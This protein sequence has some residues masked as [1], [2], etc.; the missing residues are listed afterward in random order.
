MKLSSLESLDTFALLGPGFGGHPFVL[1]TD[2]RVSQSAPQ[3]VYASFEC[4]G[5]QAQGFVGREHAVVI[6]FDVSPRPIPYSL[7]KEHYRED[8]E[9]IRNAIAAGDV[10]QVCHT[11]RADLEVESG[12]E[13]LARMCQRAIPRF[14]A[15]VRLA[16]GE[17]FVSAS[18]ELFFE[19]KGSTIRAE[20]MKGTAPEGSC[21]VLEGSD[22]DRAELAMITDLIRNDLAQVCRPGSVRVACERRVLRLPYALQTVSDVVGEIAP[23]ATPITALQVMHPGGSVTGTPKTAAIAMIRTLEPTARGA[24]CGSLGLCKETEST[25][26]ILIRTAVR[27]AQGWVY[28]VGGGIVFDSDWDKELDEVY[29]KLGALG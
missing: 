25:F 2:L 20:P 14:A 28:G 24:Y 6:D 12:A 18:P 10:Y 19:I 22:K 8:I 5:N 9:A 13:I 26:S 16:S 17:E 29:V 3:L 1:F 23:Y 15:W 21:G 11:L 7:R 27:T 4:P